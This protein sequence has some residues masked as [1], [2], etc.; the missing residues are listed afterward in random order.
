MRKLLI[1]LCYGFYIFIVLGL[2]F[3]T[4]T[5]PT[6]LGKYSPQYCF[7]LLLA[8]GLFWLY[9][10][11]V[12]STF[13]ETIINRQDGTVLKVSPTQKIF[14]YI[15]ILLVCFSACEVFLRIK[16][17]KK[18]ENAIYG[19]HPFLQNTLNIKDNKLHIN[20]DGFRGDEITK[21]KP[22]GTYRIFVVGGSTVLC[23]KMP[24]EKTH[25]RILEK[26]LQEHYQK[27]MKI[28]VLNAGNSWHTT[29]HS[30]IK[31]LFKIKD[32]DP[33]LIILWH[34]ANDLYR[35]FAPERLCHRKF[36]SDYSHFWGPLANIIFEYHKERTRYR[37]K[38]ISSSFLLNRIFM[39][40]EGRL[41]TDM[42]NAI[43]SHKQK[44]IDITEFP[45]LNSFKRNLNS[46]IQIVQ[47]DHVKL[48]L[49]TQPFLY[50]ENLSKAEKKRIWFPQTFCINEKG[51]Y[52]SIK[53]MEFGVNLFNSE[54]KKI[55]EI[56]HIPLV[57]LEAHIPKN[58]EFFYDDFHYTAKGNQLMAE[59]LFEFIT[60]NNIIEQITPQAKK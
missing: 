31:Y 30:I 9:R 55:A 25:V 60:K 10:K 7:C 3:H 36:Q 40:F 39:L 28:E 35:S 43:R 5:N 1:Y 34:A 37:P 45:S 27:Q 47:N 52:P 53:S 46:M 19:W 24:F 12:I 57:D 8:V 59:T 18:N 48:I 56:H 54:T 23:D 16:E 41:Y 26:L 32:Y 4:S 11:A 44:A 58:R 51:E 2:I 29:E 50:N 15:I 14:L 21:A 42:R 13:S 17:H 22:D 6:I 20:S 33:D 38:L 49:A